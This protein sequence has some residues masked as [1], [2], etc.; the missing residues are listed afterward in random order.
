MKGR[1]SPLNRGNI[2]NGFCVNIK[3]QYDSKYDN[4][5][6]VEEYYKQERTLQAQLDK[7]QNAAGLEHKVLFAPA[8]GSYRQGMLVEVPLQLVFASVAGDTSMPALRDLQSAV[9][10]PGW[11]AGPQSPSAQLAGRVCLFTQQAGGWALQSDVTTTPDAA[12]RS[13]GVSRLM[14]TLLRAARLRGQ[15]VLFDGNGPETWTRLERSFEELLKGFWRVGAL[16]GATPTDAFSVRCDRSTMTQNDLDNGRLICLIGVAII[17]PAEFVIFR[18][19]QKT[20][21]ARE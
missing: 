10:L 5:L 3:N 16:A 4:E 19:G 17:K 6:V 13:G 12:W 7:E 1:K 15:S 21:D 14:A 11:G 2:L 20:A 9:P 18:I 8:V